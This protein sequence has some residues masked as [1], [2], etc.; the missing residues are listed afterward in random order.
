MTPGT[1]ARARASMVAWG[2][3]TVPRESEQLLYRY[4]CDHPWHKGE[5]E[6]SRCP[7]PDFMERPTRAHVYLVR[8]NPPLSTARYEHLGDRVLV[9]RAVGGE[10]LL[11][12]AVIPVRGSC[13]TLQS[14]AACKSRAGQSIN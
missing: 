1:R 8:F 2:L 14:A 11:F 5:G 12:G 10:Q 13:T 6:V 4:S 9:G 7:S 3:V